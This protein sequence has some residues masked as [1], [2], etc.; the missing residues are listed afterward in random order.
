[1]ALWL[2][3]VTG[4]SGDS[5][6]PHLTDTDPR[7]GAREGGR[8]PADARAADA[9]ADGCGAACARHDA[10]AI[11]T[12]SL[13]A[14]VAQDAST[15]ARVDA[16]ASLDA[17]LAPSADAAPSGYPG[18]PYGPLVGDTIA[19]LRWQGYVDEAAVGLASARPWSAYSLDDVRRSGRPLLLL[20]VSDFD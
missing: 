6:A 4:C 2:V 8:G 9:Q 12:A 11:A 19:D 3:A 16:R 13:D 10:S 20:H 18:G 15:A 5:R 7:V 14:T 1:M 17:T